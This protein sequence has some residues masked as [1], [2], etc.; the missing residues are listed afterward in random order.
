MLCFKVT[1]RTG[2]LKINTT[3]LEDLMKKSCFEKIEW[4]DT[5]YKYSKAFLCADLAQL[6]YREIDDCEKA[7]DRTQLVPSTVYQ[8][9]LLRKYGKQYQEY[10]QGS[11]I[12]KLGETVRTDKF[13]SIILLINDVLFIVTRGTQLAYQE[14]FNKLIISDVGSPD[15][16]LSDP[17][18][19][20]MRVNF[21]I[22]LLRHDNSQ[23]FFHRGFYKEAQDT[24]NQIHDGITNFKDI[25]VYFVGHSL[26]GAISAIMNAL[27]KGENHTQ[28]YT[29]GMPRYCNPEAIKAYKKPHATINPYDIITKVPTISYSELPEEYRH[30]ISSIRQGI[31]C[32]LNPFKYHGI[33][34]YKQTVLSLW[35]E[36]RFIL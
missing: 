10:I 1:Q 3:P 19:A 35:K 26:G 24:L 28:S 20:D 16:L 34:T 15:D 7:G 13:V 9:I 8:D 29:Y 32:G 31:Y 23:S 33:E 11:A 17:R 18:S 30:E 27:F 2:L 4:L 6:A 21:D 14:A 22:K 12:E 25:P 5:S 36:Q